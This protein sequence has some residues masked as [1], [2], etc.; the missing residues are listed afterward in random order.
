M[1]T[2]CRIL[3]PL[4]LLATIAS[5]LR[6]YPHQLAYFNEIA[7]GPENG[8]KHLLHS[9]LDWGQD[10]L[11]AHDIL[12]NSSID[13]S[14]VKMESQS[15]QPSR[16]L[17]TGFDDASDSEITC[18]FVCADTYCSSRCDKRPWR[19]FKTKPQRVGFGLWMIINKPSST[20]STE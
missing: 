7:G 6:V 1:A 9:N 13:R 10:L 19:T 14:H 17:L 11:L 4:C 12:R 18:W 20:F 5:T 15:L 16:F 2:C 3:I 8:W